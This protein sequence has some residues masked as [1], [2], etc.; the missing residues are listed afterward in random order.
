M[1]EGAAEE[2]GDGTVQPAYLRWQ[3]HWRQR[4]GFW[5]ARIGLGMQGSRA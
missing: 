4:L 3:G 2:G 5:L 1:E